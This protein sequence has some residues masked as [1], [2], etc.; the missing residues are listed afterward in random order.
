MVGTTVKAGHRHDVL[1]DT[2]ATKEELEKEFGK[3]IA[4]LVDGVTKLGKLAFSSREER[5]AENFRK[6]LI[7][8]ARDLRVIMIKLADRLH[9]MRTLHFLPPERARKI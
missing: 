2:Q 8:M 4:E 5:Q 7:A 6:M 3:E 9:N 1:E